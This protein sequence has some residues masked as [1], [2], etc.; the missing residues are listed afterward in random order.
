MTD[1]EHSPRT[2]ATHTITSV[3]WQYCKKLI[4]YYLDLPT[5]GIREIAYS[6]KDTSYC[7]KYTQEEGENLNRPTR[8]CTS[9]YNTPTSRIPGWEAPLKSCQIF[10]EEIPILYK[11]FRRLRREYFLPLHQGQQYHPP[12]K[13]YM[14][15]YI[16]KSE[17]TLIKLTQ[18][19]TKRLIHN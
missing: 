7:W 13:N 19:H 8:K 11:I 14:N 5:S 15:I 10:Q 3:F 6:L 9:N 2:A 16:Q 17:H 18:K 4:I 12:P 1:T